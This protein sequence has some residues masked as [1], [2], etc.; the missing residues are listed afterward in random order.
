M[1]AKAIHL[2]FK[3]D[4]GITSMQE[5]RQKFHKKKNMK[6]ESNLNCKNFTSN[7]KR[8]CKISIA[9]E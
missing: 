4:V 7:D 9:I 2:I 6:P 1:N 3:I 5:C 8:N